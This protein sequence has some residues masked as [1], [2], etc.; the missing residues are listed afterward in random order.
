RKRVSALMRTQGPDRVLLVFSLVALG[1]IERRDACS[2]AE[3]AARQGRDSSCRE[4]TRCLWF[5]LEAFPGQ[6]SMLQRTLSL[7]PSISE[8]RPCEAI[9]ALLPNYR[10]QPD[11]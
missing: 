6:L 1:A 4:K 3:S 11:Y 2:E 10:H 8:R 5:I 9:Q 7:P